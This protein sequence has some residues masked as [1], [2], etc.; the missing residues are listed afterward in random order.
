MH[1][2]S[3]NELN[4]KK[5]YKSLLEKNWTTLTTLNRNLDFCSEII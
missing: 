3:H 2:Y 1:I 5:E 4:V